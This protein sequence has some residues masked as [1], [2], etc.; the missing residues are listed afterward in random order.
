MEITLIFI[1]LVALGVVLYF[2][3]SNEKIKSVSTS[4]KTDLPLVKLGPE[5]EPVVEQAP[6]ITPPVVPLAVVEPVPVTMVEETPVKKNRKPSTM[7]VQATTKPTAK[8]S[9]KKKY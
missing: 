1:G 8:K 2:K 6:I 7:K 3:H 4:E 9:N 5:P